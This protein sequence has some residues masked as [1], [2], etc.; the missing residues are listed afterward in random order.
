MNK[1]T[2]TYKIRLLLC[3]LNFQLLFYA[4][5]PG[6]PES[7]T[8]KFTRSASANFFRLD[9]FHNKEANI[10][11]KTSASDKVVSELKLLNNNCYLITSGTT[12]RPGL[13]LNNFNEICTSH[14]SVAAI[15]KT[16]PRSPPLV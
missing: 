11:Y 2:K 14:R 8:D 12:Y 7:N 5:I 9:A 16:V 6:N 10:N 4:V 1:Y 15:A 3:L 13:L